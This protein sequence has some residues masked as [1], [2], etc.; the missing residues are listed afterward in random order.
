M[1]IKNSYTSPIFLA[2]NSKKGLQ[3][4]QIKVKVIHLQHTH[5]D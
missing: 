3:K 4:L 2:Q 1:N 5:G